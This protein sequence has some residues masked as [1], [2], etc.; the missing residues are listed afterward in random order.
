MNELKEMSSA[1]KVFIMPE[2]T[3]ANTVFM[4]GRKYHEPTSVKLVKSDCPKPN[5]VK[6]LP[7]PVWGGSRDDKSARVADYYLRAEMMDRGVWWWNVS[8]LGEDIDGSAW[9]TEVPTTGKA[10]MA[11][12]EDAMDAHY[13]KSR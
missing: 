1:G 10:A 3:E 11:K 12:C 8:Y 4:D 13:K 2:A 5:D 6:Y 9:D 7:R